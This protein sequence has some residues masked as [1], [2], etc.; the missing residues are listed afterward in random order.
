MVKNRGRALDNMGQ[1]AP[2]YN[3]ERDV[4]DEVS[5]GHSVIPRRRR[6]RKSKSARNVNNQN[7]G[8]QEVRNEDNMAGTPIEMNTLLTGLQ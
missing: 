7:E 8:V 6:R 4:P 5:S 3:T 2:D 1:D